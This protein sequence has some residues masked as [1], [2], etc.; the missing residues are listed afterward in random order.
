MGSE[1][2]LDSADRK[3][4]LFYYDGSY[5]TA[6]DQ[7]FGFTYQDGSALTDGTDIYTMEVRDPYGTNVTQ[8]VQTYYVDD[9]SG[10]RVQVTDAYGD[11]HYLNSSIADRKE[12]LFHYDGSAPDVEDQVFAFEHLEEKE[13][14][15]VKVFS[16]ETR[17][18]VHSS[19]KK[20]YID[21]D[22]DGSYVEV[23]AL[24]EM[25][26]HD[27]TMPFT[28]QDIDSLAS[29]GEI[30]TQSGHKMF[31]LEGNVYSFDEGS[32]NPN[33]VPDGLYAGEQMLDG[34]DNI[35]GLRLTELEASGNEYVGKDGGHVAEI[36]TDQG[37]MLYQM[38]HYPINDF[39][40]NPPGEVYDIVD[41]D[42]TD[43]SAGLYARHDEDATTKLEPVQSDETTTETVLSA[44]N[45]DGS[46]DNTNDYAL[47]QG[48]SAVNLTGEQL[49]S[50]EGAGLTSIGFL[51][52][53][54]APNHY[55]DMTET[56]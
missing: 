47:A 10:N 18:D 22:S 29:K 38:K 26:D 30:Y 13:V 34:S 28:Q 49:D 23:Y 54:A 42:V 11:A 16:Q 3:E 51:S 2:Y 50:F 48:A 32:N 45:P 52:S 44:V 24:E 9:A 56:Q 55:S 1:H 43:I 7:V 40:W 8:T 41:G 39:V 17:T 27:H 14:E 35:I 33:G 5:P 46:T 20:F 21:P 4:D 19:H 36:T 15:G 12:D 31:P 37:D 53:E 6:E 25:V